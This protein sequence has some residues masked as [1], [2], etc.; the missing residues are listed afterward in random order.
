MSSRWN[1]LDEASRQYW[2]WRSRDFSEL[3]MREYQG[4][5][6]SGLLRLIREVMPV[7]DSPIRALDAGCGAGMLSMLLWEAGCRVT[8]VDFSSEMLAQAEKNCSEHGISGI[9]FMKM[10]IRQ[11]DL[12]EESFDFLISRNVIW[13]VQHAEE[14]YREMYRVLRKGG[15]LL[16]LDANYGAAFLEA[17]R[18][19]EIPSHPTQTLEQLRM[20]NR[21]AAGME[22][23]RR[24]RPE[25]DFSVLWECGAEEVRC[26]RHLDCS[27]GGSPGGSVSGANCELFAVI[28]KKPASPSS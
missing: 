26:I 4:P 13:T 3:R 21:I 11:M 28:A 9:R 16:N 1:E 17:D 25:W 6:H 5:S 20:R 27:L 23:S 8:A 18:K 15:V 14:G 12:E 10:D 7:Q 24:K 19:G 22:V 2:S